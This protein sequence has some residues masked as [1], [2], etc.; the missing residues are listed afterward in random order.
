MVNKWRRKAAP[1]KGMGDKSILITIRTSRRTIIK[2]K[3]KPPLKHVIIL[4]WY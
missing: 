1:N 2:E 4:G 3:K